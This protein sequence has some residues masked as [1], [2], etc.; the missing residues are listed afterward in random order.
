[1]K[2]INV[3]MQDLPFELKLEQSESK[4]GLFRVTYGKQVSKNLIYSEAAKKYGECLFHA[5]AC[6]GLLNNEG[7]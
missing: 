3:N 7:N 2:I 5:L 1:M 6:D 4:R